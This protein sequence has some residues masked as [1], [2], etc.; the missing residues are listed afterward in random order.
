MQRSTLAKRT[1]LILFIAVAAFYLY[2]LGQMPLV[3]PDEPRYAEVAREMFLRGDFVTPTLGGYTWFEKPAL[4]YWIMMGSYKLFGFTEFAARFGPALAG[5][6]STFFIYWLGSRIDKGSDEEKRSDGVGLWSGV[7]FA[8][9]LGAIVFSRGAS[10]DILLTMTVTLA[11][12]CFFIAEIERSEKRRRIL[13]AVFYFAI[14]LSLLAKGLVG[15]IIPAG[16][17]GLYYLLR[18][19]WPGKN[20]LL[21]ML[22]GVPLALAVAAIWYAPVTVRH[23]WTFIDQFFIQHHF[24]R[25]VSNK[26]HH[27]QPFYFYPPVMILMTLPWTAFL[28]AQIGQ[29]R[30][31]G[32]R[33]ENV[34]S[35]ANLFALAWLLAPILFFSFSVSKL[36]GYILPALPGAALLAGIRLSRFSSEKTG[37]IEMRLTGAALFVM[38]I[39]PLVYVARTDEITIACAL[40]IIAPLVLAGVLAIFLQKRALRIELIVSAIFVWVAL[41]LNCATTQVTRHESVRDLIRLADERGYASVPVFYMLSADRTGEFYAAG[42]LLYKPDADT[43]RFDDARE[44]AIATRQAGGT[45]LVIISTEWEKELTN[46]TGIETEVLGRNGAQ[47]L[48][49]VHA[50]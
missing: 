10:F 43:V 18:R 47:T 48:A 38:A 12:V 35:K 33:E 21:S 37:N 22:W 5:I 17:V 24:E 11:L 30:R 34:M 23:G 27:P 49:V 26:F 7:A 29:V 45:A 6:L 41:A 50:R 19:E 32:W 13:L 16:V 2:G 28:I 36:P 1:A 31:F 4:L 15:I 8:S 40:L 39:S 25:F 20:L 14:G 3:G 44:V 9:S 46:Y 42:R